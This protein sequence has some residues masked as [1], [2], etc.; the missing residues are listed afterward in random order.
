MTTMTYDC[1]FDSKN[2]IIRISISI[3]NTSCR[4]NTMICLFKFQFNFAINQWHLSINQYIDGTVIAVFLEIPLALSAIVF[5]NNLTLY[6]KDLKVLQSAIST[7][8][9]IASSLE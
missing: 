8:K 5:V 2:N 9:L 6:L 1:V 4:Q 7:L 3:I